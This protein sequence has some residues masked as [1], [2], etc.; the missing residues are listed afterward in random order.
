MCDGESIL[1]FEDDC[2]FID[3]FE[4][5]LTKSLECL[6]DD[7]DMVYLGAH[8]LQTKRVNDRWLKSQECSSTHA[9]AVKAS[10]IPKLIKRAT[11]HPG[12]VDVAY[13][14]LHNELNVYLARPTLVYQAAGFSDIQR[15]EVD[16]KDL[17]F[18]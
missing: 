13:S 16:Y 2:V 8:I 5:E 11:E 6:P 4:E 9:Y 15:V 18:R 7:W 12:H 14:T 17:Y 1:V 3:G 10:V